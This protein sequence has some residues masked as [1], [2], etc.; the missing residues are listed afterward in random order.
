MGKFP[1]TVSPP[2]NLGIIQNVIR[3][4]SLCV[5]ASI[6]IIASIAS[7]SHASRK[8]T[9]DWRDCLE[10]LG[11]VQ[12]A[13]EMYSLEHEGHYPDRFEQLVP[14]YSPAVPRCPKSGLV[15]TLSTGADSPFNT[16]GFLDFYYVHCRG[17]AHF[18]EGLATDHPGINGVESACFVRR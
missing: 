6:T 3:R 7:W 12:V 11:N 10:K 5:L 4:D 9:P 13:L 1:W 18:E 14:N 17:G 8:R 2:S 16:H 15:Y